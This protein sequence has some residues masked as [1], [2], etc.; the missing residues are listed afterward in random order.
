MAKFPNKKIVCVEWED[1]ASTNGYY[2]KEHPEKSSTAPA[3]T[4]GF[5]VENNRS[6]VKVCGESFSDGDFRHVHSIPK[7]MVRNI[8]VLTRGG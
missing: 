4:V 2:D 6:V 3:R 1:A 5:L 8:T 7:G